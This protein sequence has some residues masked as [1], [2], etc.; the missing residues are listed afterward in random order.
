MPLND[1]L[2]VGDLRNAL[3]GYDE[4]LLVQIR[5]YD[6]LIDDYVASSVVRKDMLD[7][8]Q[9]FGQQIEEGLDCPVM[10][11]TLNESE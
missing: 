11:I 1:Y 10:R 8:A 6:S 3:R 9:K 2:T 4:D 7:V 5:V